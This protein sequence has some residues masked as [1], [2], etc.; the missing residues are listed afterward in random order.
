[1]VV[2]DHG[3]QVLYSVL[4]EVVGI[5]D[6]DVGDLHAL[7]HLGLGGELGHRLRRYDAILVAVDHQPGGG[8]GG[9]EGIVVE[10]G[11]W[12]D[13]DEAV[14]FRAAHQQLHGDPGPERDAG[15]PADGRIGV[16][17]LQPVER[18]GGIGELA[19]TVVEVPLTASDAAEIEAQHGIAALHE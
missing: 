7:L 2:A 8:T 3:H 14:D 1:E 18:R 11:G 4:E 9:E 5:G 15:D 12:G 6:D 19:R 17:Q 10:V 13:A 16:L